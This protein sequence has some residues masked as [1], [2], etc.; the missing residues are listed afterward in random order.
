MKQAG[1]TDEQVAHL[2]NMG[3]CNVGDNYIARTARREVREVVARNYAQC[4]LSSPYEITRATSHQEAEHLYRLHLAEK[5]RVGP[6]AERFPDSRV[7][8]TLFIHLSGSDRQLI[9]EIRHNVEAGVVYTHKYISAHDY[10]TD[11]L[12]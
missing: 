8:Q 2:T 7:T 11:A 12:F 10:T 3:F 4:G 6:A 9:D 5:I 1:F